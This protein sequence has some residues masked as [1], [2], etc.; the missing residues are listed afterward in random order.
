MTSIG[1]KRN[2]ESNIDCIVDSNKGNQRKSNTNFERPQNR[3]GHTQ[4]GLL[5]A[6]PNL[7]IRKLANMESVHNYFRKPDSNHKRVSTTKVGI[8]D[9][10]LA[11][12]NIPAATNGHNLSSTNAISSASGNFRT[13]PLQ[14]SYQQAQMNQNNNYSVSYSGLTPQQIAWQRYQSNRIYAEN[15]YRHNN[16]QSNI[17]LP[18]NANPSKPI[19]ADRHL[20]VRSMWQMQRSSQLDRRGR[21]AAYTQDQYL[22]QFQQHRANLLVLQQQY[23]SHAFRRSEAG[24]PSH[25]NQAFNVPKGHQAKLPYLNPPSCD[26]VPPPYL[27][28]RAQN[29]CHSN[30]GI[31]NQ[32]S[33][34]YQNVNPQVTSN[35]SSNSWQVNYQKSTEQSVPGVAK[36]STLPPSVR[37]RTMEKAVLS[38]PALASKCKSTQSD[39]NI[40]Q[41]NT[42]NLPARIPNSFPLSSKPQI[43]PSASSAQNGT[44]KPSK[45]EDPLSQ[46]SKQSINETSAQSNPDKV[47]LNSVGEQKPAQKKQWGVKIPKLPEI[48]S[49]K[50]TSK[51]QSVA[52]QALRTYKH[53]LEYQIDRI[54]HFIFDNH[55]KQRLLERNILLR[56]QK[57]IKVQKKGLDRTR[58]QR[59]MSGPWIA[60]IHDRQP[61]VIENLKRTRERL[62]SNFHHEEK[63]GTLERKLIMETNLQV[64]RNE[65]LW[66]NLK[67]IKKQ[68]YEKV[69]LEVSRKTFQDCAGHRLCGFKKDELAVLRKDGTVLLAGFTNKMAWEKVS[70]EVFRKREKKRMKYMTS[71]PTRSPCQCRVVANEATLY[72]MH[73]E[74]KQTKDWNDVKQ[75]SATMLPGVWTAEEDKLLQEKTKEFGDCG[76]WEEIAAAFKD[77]RHPICCLARQQRKINK[78]QKHVWTKQEDMW[79]KNLVPILGENDWTCISR[80]FSDVTANQ[81]H[82]R[83]RN[84]LRPNIRHAQHW[85]KI[86]DLM[87]NLCVRIFGKVWVQVSKFTSGRTDLSCRERFVNFLDPTINSDA[88]FSDGEI[89]QLCHLVAKYGEGKWSKIARELNTGRTD[90]FVSRMW[91]D[92]QK[93][94]VELM[95]IKRKNQEAINKQRD[96]SRRFM[97]CTSSR[98]L[99]TKKQHA[100]PALKNRQQRQPYTRQ[101]IPPASSGVTM[102]RTAPHPHPGVVVMQP[103]HLR[104]NQYPLY[105]QL[106]P[107]PRGHAYRPAYKQIIDKEGRKRTICG[108]VVVRAGP[109]VPTYHLPAVNHPKPPLRQ[110]PMVNGTSSLYHAMR[111]PQSVP[112]RYPQLPPRYQDVSS[113]HLQ[114]QQARNAAQQGQSRIGKTSINRKDAECIRLLLNLRKQQQLKNNG[115]TRELSQTIKKGGA[116]ETTQ[117]PRQVGN[118]GTGLKRK[119]FDVNHRAHPMKAHTWNHRGMP[120]S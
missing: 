96:K 52:H 109:V 118:A 9:V 7:K 110:S 86:E 88:Q 50:A 75:T 103:S 47:N 35:S 60:D 77:H 98:K 38:P 24:P 57:K 67:A 41:S 13:T 73:P 23:T 108:V 18:L 2:R 106:P 51:I 49:T 1:G 95:R 36:E 46:S 90:W 94:G 53:V 48:S 42:H 111:R 22:N 16:A 10:N 85:T 70:W 65:L 19:L 62:P 63:P 45:A 119:F 32:R 66:N 55:E 113:S 93:N 43:A 74:S 105:P 20:P 29:K 80:Y 12:A 11:D 89:K 21:L 3:N 28:N 104:K 61:E 17:S 91:H 31:D 120:A 44:D 34:Q 8:K 101:R 102:R 117:I 15:I 30:L 33:V 27:V 82:L 68:G 115:R 64:T 72:K 76:H 83:W 69:D 25:H 71:F 81:C 5:H 87:V 6:A 4:N 99:N 39:N 14:R 26:V 114:Y 59:M 92:I 100:H 37:S 97:A 112:Y 84:T 40:I 58:R 107:L 78:S 56:G 79:L 116:A 54:R